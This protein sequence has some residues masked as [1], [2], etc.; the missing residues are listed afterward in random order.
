MAGVKSSI[1]MPASFAKLIFESCTHL[2]GA[3]VTNIM[4]DSIMNQREDKINV[5]DIEHMWQKFVLAAQAFVGLN[6]S[7]LITAISGKA[8]GRKPVL[9]FAENLSCRSYTGRFMP[10]SFTNTLIKNSCEPRLIIVSDPVF[11]KQAVAEASR[12]NCITIGF[13]NT[14]ANKEFVDIAIPVN[15]RS[16]KSIGV[17]FFILARIIKYMRDGSPLEEN[18]SEVELFFYRDQHELEQLMEEQNAET[19]ISYEQAKTG[20]ADTQDFGRAAG[21]QAAGNEAEGEWSS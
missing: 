2:G 5:F 11:D 8:F 10:G 19:K 12:I 21:V 20:D 4:Q 15:N 18:L 16:P 6:N 14:D 13:C 7:Q 17:C 3:R 9:K 1:P